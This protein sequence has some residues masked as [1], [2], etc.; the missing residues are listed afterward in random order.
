[1]K[2]LNFLLVLAFAAA[3]AFS[4][5]KDDDNDNNNNTT[6]PGPKFTEVKNIV[7]SSCAI[8]GC[9]VSPTDPNGVNLQSNANI[10]T[11][12]AKIKEMAVDL[13]LMP[14]GNPLPQS[15][16]DKITAWIEAGGRITD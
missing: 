16:Q 6:Q 3:V 8:S 2:N 12:R 9:H 4:C 13:D 15:Q 10:V 5:S 7:N 11:H 1:M 14:P